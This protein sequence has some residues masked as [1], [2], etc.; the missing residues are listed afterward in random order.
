[1]TIPKKIW[2]FKLLLLFIY[3]YYYFN[4]VKLSPIL[5]IS[6]YWQHFFQIQKCLS[7]CFCIG[8]IWSKS[9]RK[10]EPLKRMCLLF[11]NGHY[12]SKISKL[13]KRKENYVSKLKI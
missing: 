2:R 7:Q 11:F 5:Q 8:E 3:Y 9:Q 12:L 6:Q 13:K 10:N 4:G 1:L